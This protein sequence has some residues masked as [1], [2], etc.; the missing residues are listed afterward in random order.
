MG[1]RREGNPGDKTIRAKGMLGGLLMASLLLA[2]GACSDLLDVELPGRVS[3]ADLN[4]PEFAETLMLSAQGDFECALSN[5]ILAMGI[6]VTDF[7]VSSTTRTRNIFS[8][9]DQAVYTVSALGSSSGQPDC[10]ETNPMPIAMALHIAR[11]QAKSGIELIE[12]FAEVDVP[13]RAF[14]L[15]KMYAYRGYAVELL[16]E[17]MCELTLDR[18]AALTRE[19]G[20]EIARGHFTE[21]LTR[22]ATVTSGSN[23][24]EARSIEMM[25]KIGYARASLQL[26]DNAGVLRYANDIPLGFVFVADRTSTSNQTRNHVYEVTD[27]DGL[28]VNEA[29]R[30]ITV[31]GVP[32]P[33]IPHVNANEFGSDQVTPQW[34]QLKYKSWAD[35]IPFATGREM[36]L[37]VAEVE[38]ATAPQTTVQIINTLRQDPTGIYPNLDT[39][40]WPLPTFVSNDAAEI[41]TELIRERHAELFVQGGRQGDMLRF[42][43]PYAT[44]QTPKGEFYGDFTCIPL[45]DRET[46]NNDNFIN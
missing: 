43:I 13:E 38:M 36:R 22:L 25:A 32:D 14:L 6:W 44:G 31:G 5:H 1:A 2:L 42:D 11:V 26:G 8:L 15:G 45:E 17:T 9:R 18:G 12:G 20:F 10:R 4:N 23:A 3:A 16:S 39:S 30:G 46:L 35:D 41:R 7:N 29:L 24:T 34:D 28:S 33:R 37:M 40:A 19:D 21:T 27:S